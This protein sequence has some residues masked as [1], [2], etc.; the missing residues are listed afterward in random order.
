MTGIL[1]QGI[2]CA[3][4]AMTAGRKECDQHIKRLATCWKL[5]HVVEFDGIVVESIRSVR[6]ERTQS[7]LGVLEAEL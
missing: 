2:S 3:V 5:S 6:I 7:D 1:L 4:C